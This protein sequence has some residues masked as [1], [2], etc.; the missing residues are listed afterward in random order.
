MSNNIT[1]E[2]T[3]TLFKVIRQLKK[4]MSQKENCAHLSMLQI[5][6]LFFLKQNKNAQMSEIA[7]HFCIELP[8]ATS[9]LNKL[10]QMELAERTADPNDRRLVRIALTKKGEKTLKQAIEERNKKVEKMLSYLSEGE[11]NQ[12]FHILQTLDKKLEKTL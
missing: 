3:E 1:N 10:N 4:E 11:K 2:I 5:Q 8:S 12:L 7:E 6:A 9:L